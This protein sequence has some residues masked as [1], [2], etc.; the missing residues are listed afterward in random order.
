MVKSLRFGF[1]LIELLVVIAIIAVLAAILMPVFSQARAKARQ[2]ACISNEKQFGQAM[3]MY[4][5]DYD[6]VFPYGAWGHRYWMF[7]INS[8]VAGR[9]ANFTRPAG[10]IFVCP[11]DPILHYISNPAAITPEPANSWGLVRDANGQYPYWASYSINE[12][13]CDDWPNLA[14]WEA[15][16]NSFLFLEGND[17]DIEGDEIADPARCTEFRFTHNEGSNFCFVDGHVKWHRA[18]Y[19]VDPCVNSNWIF[20]PHGRGGPTGDCGPWTASTWDDQ[21]CPR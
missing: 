7:L 13:V 19:H 2:A 9:P 15:P 5:Q 11:N 1:T 14:Q 3:L 8:Y 4:V 18:V 17:S 16:A 10:N 6:E 12:H 21:P 20:P